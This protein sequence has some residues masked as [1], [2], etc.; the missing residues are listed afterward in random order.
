MRTQQD[1]ITYYSK[2]CVK[3]MNGIED[4]TGKMFHETHKELERDIY[5]A[6]DAKNM[7]NILYFH[8]KLCKEYD[9]LDGELEE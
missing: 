2:Q 5:K 1:T 4:K 8:N 6:F 9:K 3:L 7:S